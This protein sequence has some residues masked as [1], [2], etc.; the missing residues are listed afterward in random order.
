[1][2]FFLNNLDKFTITGLLAL[3]PVIFGAALNQVVKPSANTTIW[4]YFFG[5]SIG[6]FFTMLIADIDGEPR[7][8]NVYYVSRNLTNSGNEN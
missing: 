2:K 6:V 8:G 5:L 3:G 4:F 7:K 1:M